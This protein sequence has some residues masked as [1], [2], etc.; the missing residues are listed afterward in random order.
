VIGIFGGTFDPIHYGHLRTA[1]EVK[2]ALGLS[3]V[4]FI[5]AR[6]PPHR[7]PP[8]APPEARRQMLKLALKDAPAGFKLDERELLRSGPSYMVDTLRSLRQELGQAPLALLLGV[9]AFLGLPTWHEW[10]EI[11]RLAHLI[12]MSRPGYS[13]DFPALL[14][15]EWEQRKVEDPTS[16]AK[17]PGGAMYFQPVVQLEISSSF[18]RTS[19]AK[20]RDPRYLL[21][22]SVLAWIRQEGYYQLLNSE[23]RYH[24]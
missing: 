8:V 23:D 19:L 21:P 16:L 24:E 2:Q 14:Q 3:E 9:D 7:A 20:G 11:L 1:L 6:L 5:P 15:R 10:R 17:M 12:V 4:R 22:D 13:L 18:I